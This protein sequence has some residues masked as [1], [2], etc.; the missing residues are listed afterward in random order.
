M[1]AVM[2]RHRC[3]SVLIAISVATCLLAISSTA[4]ADTRQ[5]K[6]KGYVTN[7]LSPTKVE[8]EDYR[9]TRDEI[10]VAGTAQ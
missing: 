1:G 7:V 9:I 8:I 5:I 10:R 6:I 3:A 4:S 2:C